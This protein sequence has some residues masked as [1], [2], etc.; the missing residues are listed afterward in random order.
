MSQIQKDLTYLAS[1]L[2]EG[3]QAGSKGEELA[4]AYIQER[5]QAMGLSPKGDNG[6]W[7]QPFDFLFS[8]NPHI[9]E[10]DKEKLK[11]RNVVGW[12]DKGAEETVIIGAH[13]DHL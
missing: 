1:D 3:R 6:D 2:L 10:E 12:L 9:K 4:A 7:L 13:F 5:M 11:A 8:A